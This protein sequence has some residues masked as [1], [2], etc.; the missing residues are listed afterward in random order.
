MYVV[1]YIEG[2]WEFYEAGLLGTFSTIEKGKEAAEKD[3]ANPSNFYKRGYSV[4]LCIPDEPPEY[5][6]HWD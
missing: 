3:Q 1:T 6:E 4:F 5:V 2:V